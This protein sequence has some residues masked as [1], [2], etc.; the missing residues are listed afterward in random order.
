MSAIIIEPA[1]AYPVRCVQG[2]FGLLNYDVSIT[3]LIVLE[4]LL[5]IVELYTD[6]VDGFLHH[7]ALFHGQIRAVSVVGMTLDDV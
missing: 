7:N 3:L 2:T 5:Q 1:L 4:P 6:T